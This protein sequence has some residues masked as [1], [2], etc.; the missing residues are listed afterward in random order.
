MSVTTTYE[1][2]AMIVGIEA[3]QIIVSEFGGT[4]LYPLLP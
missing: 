3:A 2:I 1:N 4:E